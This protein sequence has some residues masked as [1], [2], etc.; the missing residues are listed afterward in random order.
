MKK[1][2]DLVKREQQR[3]QQRKTPEKGKKKRWN[4]IGGGTM[5]G[6]WA[7]KSRYPSDD[8][9]ESA[10]G[11]VVQVNCTVQRHFLMPRSV[12]TISELLKLPGV[13]KKV[14]RWKDPK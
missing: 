2:K 12:N 7:A 3:N 14:R 11:W 10:S 8:I 5:L 1:V 13:S 6:D 9:Y 4:H